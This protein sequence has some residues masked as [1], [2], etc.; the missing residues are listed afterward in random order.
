MPALLK[1][2]RLVWAVTFALV[3]VMGLLAYFAAKRYL[4]AVR[5][6]EHTMAVQTA[7]HATLTRLVDAETGHRGYL[8]TGDERF[9]EPLQDA[10]R[11]L[12]HEFAQLQKLTAGDS[13]Q[14]RRLSTIRR[15]SDQKLSFSHS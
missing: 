9:L 2:K 15:V 11:E 12:P 6:V 1:T 8:L 13:E 10:E 4:A 7:I 5:A 14:E 3:T